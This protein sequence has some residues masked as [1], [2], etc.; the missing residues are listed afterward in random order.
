MN[1][2]FRKKTLAVIVICLMM[3]MSLPVVIADG[4][5]KE[6]QS[7]IVEINSFNCETYAPF[8]TVPIEYKTGEKK[9]YL[10]NPKIDEDEL[11]NAIIE[12]IEQLQEQNNDLNYIELNWTDPDGPLEGGLDDMADFISFVCGIISAGLFL[13]F[14]K[15]VG[16]RNSPNMLVFVLGIIN[17]GLCT[18]NILVGFGEAF[19][20]YENPPGDGL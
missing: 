5:Q 18:Y 4:C 19:D 13:S 17:C 11:K 8:A 2:I 15:Y 20:V 7:N 10:S 12:R 16:L 14:I 9:Q 6:K 3:L 1:S